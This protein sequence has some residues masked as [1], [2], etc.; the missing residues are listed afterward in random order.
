MLDLVK[1]AVRG[2]GR[3]LEVAAGTGLVTIAVA[4]EVQELIATD[5]A[6]SMV[7]RLQSRLSEMGLANVV[8]QEADIYALKF[9]DACFDAV[10]AANVL[11]LVPHLDGALAALRRVLKPGGLLIAPT[12]CHDE[13]KLAGLVSRALGLAGF[14]G[15]RRFTAAS[16]TAAL[17][18]HH[19]T[20]TRAETIPGVIPIGY[21]QGAFSRAAAGSSSPQIVFTASR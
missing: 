19:L 18:Q 2:A 9:P 15:H 11:H 10:V 1:E 17:R 5:Y 3:V 6:S 13:T 4:S 16:L 7:K 20:L 8:T 21:V 14:P 12:F